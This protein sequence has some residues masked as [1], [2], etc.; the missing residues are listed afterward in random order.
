[1]TERN[2]TPRKSLISAA[3]R[4]Q[5]CGQKPFVLWFT[6][7]SGSGKS[8]IASALE[9][10]LV[11]QFRVH[12]AFLDGDMLR[13]G[14]NSD[15]G[16]SEQD[17]RENVRRAGEVA[18]LFYDA[19]LIT[20]VALISPFEVERQAVRNRFPQG[21]FLEIFV[22]CPL[23]VCQARDPKGLYK[24]AT[25]GEIGQFTGITSPYEAPVD[26]EVI[27]DTDK[28]SVEECVSLLMERLRQAGMLQ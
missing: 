2:L 11:D 14:L 22:S 21:L 28:S 18:R 8:T 7:L 4:R 12:T 13:F 1:M 6:G 20:L 10:Q 15:L 24:K 27:L 23:E 26:P 3:E 19:G 17:R 5:L 16:F 9:R 25:K